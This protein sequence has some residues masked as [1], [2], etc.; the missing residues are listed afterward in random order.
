MKSC[1]FCEIREGREPGS[2][3]YEDKMVTA[4]MTINPANPGHTLI[5]PK[6]HVTSLSDVGAQLGAELFKISVRVAEAIKRSGV[7][8]DGID[9][10]LSNGEPQKEILHLHMHVIPRFEGDGL[11]IDFGPDE[12]G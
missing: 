4:L 9:L 8:C 2:I 12:A 11:E 5:V 1:I 7:R 10:F 3:V 6:R